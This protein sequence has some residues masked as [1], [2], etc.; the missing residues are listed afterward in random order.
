MAWFEFRLMNGRNL[1][2]GDGFLV[3]AR[4]EQDALG[5][6]QSVA[7]DDSLVTGEVRRA[8]LV[9]E[10]PSPQRDPLLQPLR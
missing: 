1:P 4:T 3:V 6:G 7:D 10:V 9:G 2:V 8:V 5:L